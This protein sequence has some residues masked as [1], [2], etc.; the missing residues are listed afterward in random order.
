LVCSPCYNPVDGTSTG[1][2]FTAP[3]DKPTTPAPAPYKACGTYD[4]GPA[5]GICVP[6]AI[7]LAS[8]NPAAPSLKQDP[9]C[10]DGE[11]CTPALK[12]NGVNACFDK[13]QTGLGFPYAEGACVPDFV[14][15]DINAAAI[16]V[17]VKKTTCPDNYLC[18]PCADP[19]HAGMASNS[20]M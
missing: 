15:R 14:V 10:A 11:V 9:P 5:G 20:C 12:A 6:K 13:C 19:Q 1:A 18:A 7:A 2:C 4:G 3:G 8:G 16:G 17:I